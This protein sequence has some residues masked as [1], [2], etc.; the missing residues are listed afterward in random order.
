MRL[1][2]GKTASLQ[3]DSDVAIEELKQSAQS[4]LS[5]G[6]SLLVTCCG[7]LLDCASTIGECNLRSEDSV[8]LHVGQLPILANRWNEFAASGMA[9]ILGDGSVVTW[10]LADFEVAAAVRC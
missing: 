4:A 8:T 1:I 9:A 7:R 6:R 2:R 5:V 3:T 10:G